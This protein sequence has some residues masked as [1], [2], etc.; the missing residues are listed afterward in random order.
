MY[1]YIALDLDGTILGANH[2][3]S[4]R[5]VTV[6]KKLQKK[7]IIIILCSGRNV[8][9]MNFVAEKINTDNHD[10]F[11]V[12]DNGGVITEIDKGVRTVLKNT[13][14]ES[15]ELE[16]IVK[17]VRNRTKVLVTFNDGRRYLQKLNLREFIRGYVR[18]GEVSKIGLPSQASKLLL[19]DN[20]NKIEKIYEAVKSDV[21]TENSQLNV[22]RSVPHLIEITPNGSTKGCGLKTVFERKGWSL[23]DLIV[24]GDGENDISMFQVAGKAVAMRNA[25]DTVKAEAD[26]ICKSNIEDGVSIYLEQLYA[27]IL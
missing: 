10:T 4:K 11:I 16:Q 18:F 22:F 13:K 6:L 15:G 2:D 25:F 27:S 21:L 17:V 3:I 26:D 20:Q 23:E 12:S 1:K 7:G 14:F 8:S 19:I 24:F 5:C 9:Q